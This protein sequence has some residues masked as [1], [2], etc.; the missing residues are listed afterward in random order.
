MILIASASA[1]W[2]IGK[3]NELLFR[4]SADMRRFRRLTSGNVVVMGRR[5]LESMP[6]RRPLP[7]RVNIVLSR[8]PSFAPDGVTMARSVP[9]LL[10]QL[11]DTG[12]KKTFVIGGAAVY[13]TLLPYCDTAYITRFWAQAEADRFLPD[14]SAS[15]DWALRE[16]SPLYVQDGL[17]YTFD[18]YIRKGD[19]LS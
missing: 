9:D 8:D 12:Q 1:D 2:G 10:D 16:R 3:D 7:D 19:A 4:V 18:T 5:T 17:Y 6:G 14:L 13:E 11:R 15:P